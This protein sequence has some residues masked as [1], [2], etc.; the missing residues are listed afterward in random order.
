MR[1]RTC[2][3]KRAV[4]FLLPPLLNSSR[5]K[6]LLPTGIKQI[7]LRKS[8]PYTNGMLEIVLVCL[9]SPK[10]QISPQTALARLRSGHIKSLKFVDKG[11]DL[12][13]LLL[14]LSCFSCS[15]H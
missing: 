15:C 4:L 11:I 6:N 2:L 9:Y 8:L 14:L 12:F 7:L 3:P 10:V 1:W 5:P 13:L